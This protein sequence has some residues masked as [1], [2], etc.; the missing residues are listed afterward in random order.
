MWWVSNGN[1]VNKLLRK[2]KY[3]TKLNLVII[4]TNIKLNNNV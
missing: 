1:K 4:V 3:C 2:T